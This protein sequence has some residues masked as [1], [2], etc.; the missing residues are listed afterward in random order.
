MV[1]GRI[2]GVACG[3]FLDSA[4][5]TTLIVSPPVCREHPEFVDWES[6]DSRQ[7]G[8]AR[9]HGGTALGQRP[10]HQPVWAGSERGGRYARTESV[11]LA[12]VPTDTPPVV[13][14]RLLENYRLT[15]DYGAGRMWIEDRPVPSVAAR[16]AAGMDPNTP[17]PAD[18][19]PLMA[20]AIRADVAGVRALLQAGAKPEGR[21][22]TGRT[23]LMWAVSGGNPDVVQP[24]LT[25]CRT[26]VNERTVRDTTALMFAMR[27]RSAEAVVK[28]L[29]A[30]GA[31]VSL[32]DSDGE[33]AMHWAARYSNGAVIELLVARHGDVNTAS[34]TGTRPLDLAVG[35][36]RIATVEALWRAACAPPAKRELPCCTS[37][38][39]MPTPP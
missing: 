26:N 22:A 1:A 5:D 19:T 23:A 36:G 28:I 33:S 38:P 8:G 7:R 11:P 35:N 37:P 34:K 24:L 32:T 2:G 39:S 17:D 14:V 29:L 16:L 4:Y 31:N 13:G 27:G 18:T 9:R 25:A 20:A 15:F 10:R 21:D 12:G 30:A 6:G 3:L